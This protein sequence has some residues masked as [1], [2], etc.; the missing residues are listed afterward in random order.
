MLRKEESLLEALVGIQVDD[1]ICAIT[2]D[3][4]KKENKESMEFSSKGNEIVGEAR[5]KFN[6]VELTLIKMESAVLMKQ[7]EYI[8]QIGKQHFRKGISFADFQSLWAK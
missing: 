1:T 7:S 5:T 4:A 6:G 8:A 3:S 2:S